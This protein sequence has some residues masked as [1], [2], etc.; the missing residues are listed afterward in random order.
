MNDRF[1]TLFMI[2]VLNWI[3][4][5][6]TRKEPTRV[7]KANS[8]KRSKPRMPP[9]RHPTRPRGMI[10]TLALFFSVLPFGAFYFLYIYIFSLNFQLNLCSAEA[11][12][13]LLDESNR[14]L[15]EDKTALEQLIESLEIEKQNLLDEKDMWTQE[16]DSMEEER[17]QLIQERR[18]L[19]QDK[20]LLEQQK[21]VLEQ[22]KQTL[23]D[24]N[25]VLEQDKS[26][27]INRIS[28]LEAQPQSSA[29]LSA[30]ESV[31]ASGWEQEKVRL[32]EENRLLSSTM[33]ML[34]SEKSAIEQAL[35]ALE[36]TAQALTLQKQ[37]LENEHATLRQQIGDAKQRIASPAPLQANDIM[38]SVVDWEQAMQGL[39]QLDQELRSLKYAKDELEQSIQSLQHEKATLGSQSTN[40]DDNA[41]SNING[42]HGWEQEK[43]MLMQE[44]A[45]FGQE[46]ATVAQA[47]AEL[48]QVVQALVDEKS[49]I[50]QENMAL[51][52]SKV[53]Q[54]FFIRSLEQE[55]TEALCRI[56]DL[57]AQT[58]AQFEGSVLSDWMQEKSDLQQE[59][60]T[61][62]NAKSA[63]ELDKSTLEQKN[64]AMEHEL[65][66]TVGRTSEYE[67]R[68]TM[69]ETQL[70]Q[71]KSKWE[72]ATAQIAAQEK[73]VTSS[74]AHWLP[75][76]F[77][78]NQYFLYIFNFL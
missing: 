56:S 31:S 18:A 30:P 55:R 36:Q 17:A 76:L 34:K 45:V 20:N 4:E 63:L 1:L 37:E 58:Q 47:K 64:K 2:C 48:E 54:D 52:Q 71:M 61:L 66:K 68:A 60:A 25:V 16:R 46:Y 41:D 62:V 23:V 57:E 72:D 75:T 10:N 11:M 43:A 15:E 51:A 7:S 26:E 8:N 53:D 6:E 74:V 29:S 24:V 65:V 38:S 50:E 67:H 14:K 27:A 28:V 12:I 70:K 39:E 3:L 44:Q 22:E 32:E 49:M 40:N 78:K 73:S 33:T 9:P 21:V 77:L 59:N 35:V 19:T 42:H 13:A 5:S 69:M